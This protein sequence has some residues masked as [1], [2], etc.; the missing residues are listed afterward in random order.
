MVPW[1]QGI[2]IVVEKPG[3]DPETLDLIEPTHETNIH[4]TL[5]LMPL[6]FVTNPW[7]ASVEVNGRLIGTTDRDGLSVP[8]DQGEIVIEKY[9]YKSKKLTFAVPPAEREVVIE[10]ELDEPSAPKDVPKKSSAIVQE[11]SEAP[12]S[13]PGKPKE[14]RIITHPSG[15]YVSIDGRNQSIAVSGGILVPW[16]QGEIL[17]EKHGYKSKKLT[18]TA[19]P[20]GRVFDIYL[21]LD[22]VFIRH[23][24][25]VVVAAICAIGIIIPTAILTYNYYPT[26]ILTYNYYWKNTCD[27]HALRDLWNLKVAMQKKIVD[28]MLSSTRVVTDD[29]AL[30]KIVDD[31]LAD[32]TGKFGFPGP[33]VK[34]GVTLTNAR[35]VVTAKASQGTNQGV[36]GWTLNVIEGGR[37]P[38]PVK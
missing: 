2:S 17:I 5:K 21:K 13:A 7:G 14:V 4:V 32:S 27:K 29:A 20:I 12:D 10:L 24:T 6:R 18:F 38:V 19:P 28:D 15:A 26:A 25:F 8:R 34:C 3:Y 35:G 9:G 33:T 11:K 1:K 37:D 22:S 16:N 36:K 23:Q 31:I 30:S